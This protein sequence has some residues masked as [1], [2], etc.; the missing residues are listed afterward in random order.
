MSVDRR[1][2]WLWPALASLLLVAILVGV[3]D[4]D[5]A[6]GLLANV[7][8]WWVAAALALLQLEGVCTAL[9]IRLLAGPGARLDASLAA[10]AWWVVGL[11]VLPAR[12]GEVGGLVALR[13][14]LGQR[15]GGA[16]NSLLVQR[17]VDA[18][19]L[20]VLGAAV[21]G[22]ERARS[23]QGALFG[24]TLLLAAGCI[25]A[26]F[27]LPL[28]F[29]LAARLAYRWRG[30]VFGR[31]LLRMAVDGRRAARDLARGGRLWRLGGLSFGKWCCNL[32][33][34]GIL[35]GLLLPQLALSARAAVAVLF[36]L[37][38]V[39]PL[40]TVGGIGIGEVAFTAGFRWYDVSLET[41]AS[42]AL[43]LRGALF[44]AP[45]LFW[46]LALGGLAAWPRQ[47]EETS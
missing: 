26:L 24:L 45:V 33:A 20:L 25:L 28:W 32:A 43:L 16:I 18:L 41:A 42:A 39:I 10:T 37:A 19:L 17:L 1:R 40:Q 5:V 44:A 2:G 7:S 34:L 23:G 30:R 15:S 22:A 21:L 35:I 4:L 29:A 46:A 9:R 8:W 11:A 13:R 31:R 47:A 27:A 38:A 3:A 14:Y 12:L 36:N 6:R